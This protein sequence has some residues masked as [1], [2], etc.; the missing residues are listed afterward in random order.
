MC[1]YIYM[2]VCVYTHIH[3]KG[4]TNE[5]RKQ[6]KREYWSEKNHLKTKN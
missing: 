2:C 4:G 5:T 6:A 1:V 3:T